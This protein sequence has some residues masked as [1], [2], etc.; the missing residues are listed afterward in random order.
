MSSIHSRHSESF[1]CSEVMNSIA[2]NAQTADQ[3]G[4][5]HESSLRTLKEQGYLGLAVPVEF[6]GRGA[7]LSDCCEA[8][9]ALGRA[10]SGLAVAFTMH[11]FTVGIIVEHWRRERDL[12]WA[13]LEAIATQNLV[14]CSAFA[15]PGLGGSLL[16]SQCQ[17]TA[18]DGGFR[19]S[20]IKVP[21]SLAGRSDLICLQA[22]SNEDR[23][24]RLLIIVLPTKTD[25]V[26]VRKSWNGLGM[27]ASES[28]T[29][30]FEDCFVPESVVFHRCK[31]GFDPDDTFA[32]G[33]IWFCL[34]M[35]SSYL[36]LVWSAFDEAKTELNKSVIAHLNAPR[37][38]NSSFQDVVG[39]LAASLIS[40]ESACFGLAKEFED[41]RA[42]VNEL[43][44]RAVAIKH[45]AVDICCNAVANLMETAGAR[46]YSSESKLSRL[47]RDVN[48]MRFHPP[49]RFTSR[50][51]IGRW[52]L[53]RP[54]SFEIE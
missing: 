41:D 4:S 24:D 37:S 35:T 33:L 29:L 36:G 18:V 42:N 12:S 13:L 39:D 54:F 30:I 46:A 10:D 43:L 25:G 45:H 1:F 40:I 22:L 27:R 11:L 8:Q 23:E 48:A 49:T 7:D 14:I 34:M 26:S 15:E 5:I 3:S 53:G 51:I 28:D 17:A 52:A 21:C 44:P 38:A 31:P 19:L 6:G 32:A 20:G 9:M 47:V 50:Q 2:A 16:R